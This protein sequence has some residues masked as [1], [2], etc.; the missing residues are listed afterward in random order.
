MSGKLVIPYGTY[1]CQECGEFFTAEGSINHWGEGE[2]PA[3][4]EHE[5]CPK[6]E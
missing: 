6:A 5:D 1:R 4:E 3:R 2:V